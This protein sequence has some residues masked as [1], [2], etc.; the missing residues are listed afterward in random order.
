MKYAIMESGGKQYK[1]VPG[2]TV[3][4][5]RLPNEVNDK[6]D[7]EKVLLVV[8]DGDIKIGT[9]V[10]EGVTI[11]ATVSDQIKGRKIRVFKY[12]PKVRYRKRQGHRQRYTLLTI[13]EIV[14][15]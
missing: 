4:V 7:L 13:D 8:D 15:D 6:I 10:L 12:K 3:R 14:T 2:E 1:A 5:D 11:K 9:P